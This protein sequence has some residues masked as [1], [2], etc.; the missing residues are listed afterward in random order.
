M[1]HIIDTY[2]M[3]RLSY[4]TS[5]LMLKT[6]IIVLS[7]QYISISNSLINAA[8]LPKM[9]EKIS[10]LP[11]R[12]IT[13]VTEARKRKNKAQACNNEKESRSCCQIF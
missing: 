12:P 3:N 1:L 8:L 4:L 13:M 7:S 9:M 10:V 11:Q 5:L 6:S 2:G